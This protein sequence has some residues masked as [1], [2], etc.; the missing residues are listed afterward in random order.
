[1]LFIFKAFRFRYND[2]KLPKRF[3]RKSQCDRLEAESPAVG[4]LVSLLDAFFNEWG[5]Y[6]VH[7]KRWTDR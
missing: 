6:L 3:H 1:M 4:F 5:L 7:H 2:K